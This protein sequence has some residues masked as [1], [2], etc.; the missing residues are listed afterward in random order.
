[1]NLFGAEQACVIM[2]PLRKLYDVQPL[3]LKT[4]SWRGADAILILCC[5][6]SSMFLWIQG[7]ISIAWPE[8]ILIFSSFLLPSSRLFRLL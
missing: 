1:M 6:S 5:A 3:T 2:E 7:N 4:A 8:R